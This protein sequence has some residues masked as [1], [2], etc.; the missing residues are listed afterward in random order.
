MK[1]RKIIK[2]KLAKHRGCG[3]DLPGY[4][5]VFHGTIIEGD[6]VQHISYGT[7]EPASGLVTKRVED[8]KDTY[9]VFRK[10]IQN[11]E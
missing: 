7:Y 5:Q 3:C 8:F 6:R 2:R 9:K 11:I 10:I 1:A 4:V